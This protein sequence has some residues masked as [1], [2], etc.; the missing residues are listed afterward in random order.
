MEKVIR[1]GKVAIL[2][3]PGYGSGW[4]SCNPRYKELLFH[5]KLVAM[6]ES[7][8]QD[9]ITEEWVRKEL[10]IQDWIYCG[11][12]KSLDIEWLPEGTAFTVEDYDGSESIRTINDLTLMA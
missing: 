7:G 4:Y 1:D 5:P 9:E 6:V 12:A 2:I 10:G 3:S 11:G 8:N